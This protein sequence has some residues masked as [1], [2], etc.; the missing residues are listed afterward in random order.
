MS[1]TEGSIWIFLLKTQRKLR[2]LELVTNDMESALW[3]RA[4]GI[5]GM[6][7]NAAGLDIAAGW[8]DTWRTSLLHYLKSLL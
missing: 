3:A 6:E 1:S 7:Q 5:T 8:V 2:R 4:R